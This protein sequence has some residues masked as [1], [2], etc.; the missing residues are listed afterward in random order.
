[1]QTSLKVFDGFP[2]DMASDLTGL[3]PWEIRRF[4]E[5]GVIHPSKQSGN[6]YKFSFADILM[7][8]LC[9]HLRRMDVT[10][11]KIGQ[12]HHYLNRLDPQKKL[13]AYQLYVRKDTGDILFFGEGKYD[14]EK[15]LVSA[16]KFG[17]LCLKGMVHIIPVGIHL[18]RLRKNVIDL[19]SRLDRGMKAKKLI[20]LD[21]IKK[22]YGLG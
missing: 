2:L 6:F 12:A 10:I 19:D 5:L 14:E 7:L 16:S 17:Q 20:P 1:M 11:K 15:A 22:Q 13:D 4:R 3:K 9:K 18:E 21:E 8:R